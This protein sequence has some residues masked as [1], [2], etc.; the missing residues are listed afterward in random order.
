MWFSR[1]ITTPAFLAQLDYSPEVVQTALQGRIPANTE[2][3]LTHPVK[4]HPRGTDVS[5]HLKLR[6]DH[7]QHSVPVLTLGEQ[8]REACKGAPDALGSCEPIQE[9]DLLPVYL[10]RLVTREVAPLQ[11]LKPQ[12]PAT[13]DEPLR[14]HPA[15]GEGPVVGIGHQTGDNCHS[16][17]PPEP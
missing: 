8:W 13:C 15:F 4:S 17:Y 12:F 9:S 10:P 3:N 1:A 6:A 14:R 5:R 2:L 11:R 7:R 16:D